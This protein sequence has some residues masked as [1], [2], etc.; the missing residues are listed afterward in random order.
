MK[1]I[2]VVNAANDTFI[3]RIKSRSIEFINNGA[4]DTSV[5]LTASAKSASISP[6]D[7][8]LAFTRATKNSIV[9]EVYILTTDTWRS[10]FQ[11]EREKIVAKVMFSADGRYI[12]LLATSGM[13][14]YCA[15]TL[16]K[17]SWFYFTREERDFW[18]MQVRTAERGF[19]LYRMVGPSI[20][21]P[22]I[23]KYM[24]QQVDYRSVYM[25]MEKEK[26]QVFYS[27]LSLFLTGEEV[28]TIIKDL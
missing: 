7:T 2:R 13:T 12:F 8:K 20:W 26:M 19:V 18:G 25:R 6:D 1:I 14:M 27:V 4:V 23:G 28:Y 16:R 17:L 5:K 9:L 10:V 24:G 15:H 11:D 21:I 3:V 22:I